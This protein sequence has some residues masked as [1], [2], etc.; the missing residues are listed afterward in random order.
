MRFCM[1]TTFYPPFSFGGD[2]IGVQRLSRALARRG[3]QITVVHD[4]DAYAALHEGPL[5]DPPEDDDGVRVIR[6]RSGLGTLGP[7]LVHQLGTRVLGRRRLRRLLSSG[8]F[9]VVNFHNPSLIGGPGILTWPRDAITV[10]TAHEH[11]LVCPTHVLWRSR[12]E[13]CDRRHCIRCTLAYRRPPQLWRYTD[14]LPRALERID[15]VIALSE[16]SRDKHREFGLQREM[17]VLPTFLP[18]RDAVPLLSGNRPHGRP[19][20]LSAGRLELIKGLDDVIPVFRD[21]PG[22][23]LVIAGE[24]DHGEQLRRVAAGSENVHFLGRLDPEALRDWFCHAVATLVPSVCYEAFANVVVESFREGTPIV[25]RAV[26]PLPETV[27]TSG[28]GLLFSSPEELKSILARLLR[29]PA[30]REQLAAKARAAFQAR[31][32]EDVVIPRY[33]DLIR[34]AASRRGMVHLLAKPT[35]PTTGT[36]G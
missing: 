22:V 13:R 24:G 32:A 6:L 10:Y 31:W 35:S 8:Q 29:N 7:L 27:T 21:L 25:A 5:P 18:A 1:V 12:R 19:Y 34:G 2:A 9:D 36:V 4:V 14:L 30:Q 17:V 20:F 16:F 11:W 28:A 3:H 26:G 15:V 33:L 23:D